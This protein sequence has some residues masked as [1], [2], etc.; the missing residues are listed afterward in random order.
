[1]SQLYSLNRL[2]REDNKDIGTTIL[3]TYDNAGNITER[4]KYD[5][6]T[7]SGEE[8]EELKCEHY[9]YD[10]E[11]DRLVNYNG[12][13][14]EYNSLGNPIGED[15][16]WEYGT[17]LV[18]WYGTEFTYDGLGRRTSKT[19]DGKIIT[20][21]YD[22]DGRLIK[23]SNGLEFIYDY[24][25]VVGVKYNNATYF[26]RRDA[27]GNII[28]ILD[29][30]GEVVVRYYYD[31][32]GNN[33]VTDKDG[34]D[35]EDGIGKLNPFRYRGYY[36]DTETGLYYLQTRYYD[37]ELG[38]FISQDSIEYA[39]P[40]T[41]NGLNL[42]A[43]CGNN[44]VMN[45]DPSGTWSWKKFWGWVV[46]GFVAVVAVAAIVVGSVFTGG[47]LSAVLV[48]AGAGALFAMGGSIITQGGFVSADPWKVAKAGGIGAA[49]GAISGAA[50][51]GM[52][53]I[54]SSL[55]EFLGT[56]F[57]NATHLAS[58]IKFGQVF[59]S[60]I[61][62]AIGKVAGNIVGG[63]IGGSGANYF[64]NKFLGEDLDLNEFIKQGFMGEFPMWLVS[65]FKWL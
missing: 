18:K 55:G 62:S 34:N 14:F 45:V 51:Y 35:V 20:F 64:A 37:P 25:G 9:S 32:W 61:L 42:Y 56:S 38:R 27:Q 2:I 58:G 50:S 33:A 15:I 48:G 3:F 29:S 28:A 8:L 63:Y 11:G 43:Y 53:V 31:A 17:R 23:Q 30:N 24:S 49:I 19:K 13:T 40:E 6:T 46:T 52:G 7:K 57:G 65:F 54:G 5:Y 10:Y 36:Y 41:I 39:D 4:C 16:K 60:G 26:Y 44:P 22:S 1:M 47:L 21:T 59:N 12:K